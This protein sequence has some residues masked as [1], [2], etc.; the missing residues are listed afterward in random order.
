MNSKVEK[1]KKLDNFFCKC[2]QINVY[3]GS[4]HGNFKIAKKQS[5]KSYYGGVDMILQSNNT[6]YFFGKFLL[7]ITKPY[8]SFR[9]DMNRLDSAISSSSTRRRSASANTHKKN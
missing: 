4:E 3:L 1:L 6:F 7:S 5:K 9:F 8:I 2:K